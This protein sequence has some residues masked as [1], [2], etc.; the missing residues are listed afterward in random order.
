M[1]LFDSLLSSAAV[2]ASFSC[3]TDLM[4]SEVWELFFRNYGCRS[5]GKGGGRKREGRGYGM[6]YGNRKRGHGKGGKFVPSTD[7]YQKVR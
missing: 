1:F 5:K 6:E 3:M 2:L 4:S 7:D